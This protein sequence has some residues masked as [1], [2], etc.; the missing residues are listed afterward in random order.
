MVFSLFE[1]N[2]DD[3]SGKRRYSC[4]ILQWSKNDL[5][6]K[7]STNGDYLTGLFVI[8]LKQIIA[9]C[10]PTDDLYTFTRERTNAVTT[11]EIFEA[12]KNPKIY[13]ETSL[14]VCLS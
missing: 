1:T 13:Y 12:H 8:L 9:C 10:I 2:N 5:K 6:S 4:N 7:K 3:V 14:Q 11:D